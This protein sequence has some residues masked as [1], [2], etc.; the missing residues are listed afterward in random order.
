MHKRNIASVGIGCGF[1]ILCLLVAGT[2]WQLRG[3]SNTEN[4]VDYAFIGVDSPAEAP[5][6]APFSI[7]VTI[8]KNF[9][10][11]NTLTIHSVDFSDTYLQGVELLG[12]T[13]AYEND[14]SIPLTSF[15]SFIFND[16]IAQDDTAVIEFKF[17][18]QQASVLNGIMDICIN[19]ASLCQRFALQTT[20]VA[21]N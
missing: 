6:A 2:M 4:P 7:F 11:L 16:E 5:A 18:S 8:Q 15:H 12:T 20:I 17:Q 13:P 9:G 1:L 21:D 3:L 19:T 14:F 10:N